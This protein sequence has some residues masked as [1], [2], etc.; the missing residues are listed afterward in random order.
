LA[1]IPLFSRAELAAAFALIFREPAT[2][3]RIAGEW[4]ETFVG[5]AVDDAGRFLY[6]EWWVDE[7]GSAAGAVPATAAGESP[8]DDSLA[9]HEREVSFYRGWSDER[10]AELVMQFSDFHFALVALVSD[11]LA[12][13]MN[14]ARGF[15]PAQAAR[16]RAQMARMAQWLR[17]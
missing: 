16:S 3:E 14:A 6:E 2:A 15:T 5:D 7:G 11:E 1:R 17:G 9:A 10:K 12:E 4:F 8:R 13:R